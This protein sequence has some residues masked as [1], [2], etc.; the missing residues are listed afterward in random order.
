MKEPRACP[1]V[2]TQE[3]QKLI[4]RSVIAKSIS[5]ESEHVGTFGAGVWSGYTSS[6]SE[7]REREMRLRLGSMQE[8]ES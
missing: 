8:L 4:F 7:E 3:M 1:V 6:W 2:G 5:L